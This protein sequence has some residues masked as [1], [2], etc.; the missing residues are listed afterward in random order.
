MWDTA[1]RFTLLDL[2]INPFMSNCVGRTFVKLCLAIIRKFPSLSEFSSN[3]RNKNVEV[4]R[5]VLVRSNL[6]YITHSKLF[7][8]GV[9]SDHVLGFLICFF[10]S[11]KFKLLVHY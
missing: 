2:K 4:F 9:S 1:L 11:Q 7:N 10:W 6:D 8:L 3:Y 5:Q